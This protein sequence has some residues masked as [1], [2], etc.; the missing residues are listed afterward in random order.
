MV[1]TAQGQAI[2]VTQRRSR[3]Y[4][5]GPP[6]AQK[7]RLPIAKQVHNAYLILNLTEEVESCA[8]IPEEIIT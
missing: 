8:D 4:L 2:A 1:P 7:Y 5:L 6:T 3:L